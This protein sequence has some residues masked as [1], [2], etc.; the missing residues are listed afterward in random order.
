MRDT[1]REASPTESFILPN[2]TLGYLPPPIPAPPLPPPTALQ[3]NLST[4]LPGLSFGGYHSDLFRYDNSGM[5][6][7][8]DLLNY[9][10][11]PTTTADHYY[12]HNSANIGSVHSS[13]FYSPVNKWTDQ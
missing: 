1:F 8:S 2:L 4:T 6:S 10:S 3:T 12:L 13:A 7:T 5:E 9:G 11:I